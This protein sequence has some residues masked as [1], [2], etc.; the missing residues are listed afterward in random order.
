MDN[1]FGDCEA[2]KVIYVHAK[3]ADYYKKHLP[4]ELHALIVELPAEKKAKKK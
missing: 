1:V 3:K 2:L 4:E